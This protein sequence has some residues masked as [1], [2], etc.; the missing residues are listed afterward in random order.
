MTERRRAKMEATQ[1]AMEE[2]RESFHAWRRASR[3]LVFA[4]ADVN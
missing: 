1:Q 2:V 4:G 3:S